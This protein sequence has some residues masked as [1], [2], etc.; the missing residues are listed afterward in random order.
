MT[1]LIHN[2]SRFHPDP[3]IAR[4]GVLPRYQPLSGL[5]ACRS[6]LKDLQHWR[7]VGPALT[8]TSQLD[9]RGDP[10]PVACGRPASLCRRRFWLVYSD[11][12]QRGRGLKTCTIMWYGPRISASSGPSRITSTVVVLTRRFPWHDGKKYVSNMLV[13]HRPGKNRFAGILVQNMITPPASSL[14]VKMLAWFKKQGH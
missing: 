1:S 5:A 9:M 8:R 12:K 6:I 4:S 13:D 3:T 14:A 11:M 2:H 7:I 10:I